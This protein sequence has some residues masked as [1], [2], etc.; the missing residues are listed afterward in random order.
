MGIY[1]FSGTFTGQVN[2]LYPNGF[3]DFL[4]GLPNRQ[5]IQFPLDWDYSRLRNTR[6]QPYIQDDIGVTP[7][8]TLNL[9][10]RWDWY[11]P[12]TEVNNRFSSFDFSTGQFVYPS[13]LT[14]PYDLPFPHRFDENLTAMQN[15]QHKEFAPRVGFAWRP[16]SNSR[17]V[18][19][20][21][22][23]I[24]WALPSGYVHDTVARNSP[25]LNLLDT[26]VSSN[27]TPQLTWGVF[28]G[29]QSPGSLVPLSPSGWTVDPFTFVNP[30]IQQWNL[31]VSLQLMQETA[32]KIAYVGNRST[33]LDRV[34][35]GNAALPPGPGDVN[36]RRLFP[37]FRS[38]SNSLSNAQATYNAL[39]VSVDRRFA[40]GLTFMS[41]Y[42]WS[43]CIDD[44]S[45]F[46]LDDAFVQNPADV[47][48]EKGR[49]QQDVRNRFTTA[50]VYQL[51]FQFHHPFP[52]N[53]LQG[54]GASGV[55]LLQNGF[56]FTI[57]APGDIPNAATGNTRAEQIVGNAA[58][59]P[60]ARSVSKWFNTSAFALPAP[61]TFGN[62]RR[63][64]LDGPGTISVDFALMKLFSI[65]E[66][67]QLQFRAEFF[68]II[69]H[70]NFS[71]PQNYVGAGNFGAISR[72]QGDNR[73]IQLA[74]K[75]TF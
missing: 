37:A 1:N 3:G 68:N 42:T 67:Q 36:A 28:T 14:L 32:L 22:Y 65:T 58:L 16:L 19:Q 41:S 48:S 38:I 45:G 34:L 5:S 74:L 12:W 43:K 60:S 21:A 72:T 39:Q 31:G 27:T 13:A 57:F 54:W 33:H 61:Y 51:P 70:P 44:S 71:Y 73:Q 8:F 10:L 35:E 46:A 11:G 66:R 62:S 59:S 9:G 24:F 56:P 50:Y 26:E 53:V 6:V 29:S 30:Y 75:Y 69:N 4:L 63:Y 20:G 64:I 18:I 2:D 55:I 15:A 17:A 25:G 52:R 47:A 40:Q 49:C 23:G 7:S